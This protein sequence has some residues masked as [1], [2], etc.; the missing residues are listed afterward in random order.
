MTYRTQ[1]G[2]LWCLWLSLSMVFLFIRSLLYKLPE[3]VQDTDWETP[4]L[5]HFLTGT[6]VFLLYWLFLSE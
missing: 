6:A 1:L 2:D 5:I 4:Q 3:N